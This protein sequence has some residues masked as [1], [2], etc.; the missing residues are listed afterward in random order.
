[1]PRDAPVMTATFV[2]LLMFSSFDLPRH[3]PRACKIILDAR[4]P[5]LGAGFVLV[6]ARRTRDSERTDDFTFGLDRDPAGERQNVG[7]RRENS[8]V[9]IFGYELRE[10][11]RSVE[12]KDRPEG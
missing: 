1:M 9:W 7:Q 10:H 11:A 2:S 4:D 12:P 8:A 5:G 6:A 3:S